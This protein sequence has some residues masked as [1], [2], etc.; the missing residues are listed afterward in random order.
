MSLL[1]C[2]S[3]SACCVICL[4]LILGAVWSVL[5]TLSFFGISPCG[6]VSFFPVFTAPSL[7]RCPC[8][9]WL[10]RTLGRPCSPVM[11]RCPPGCYYSFLISLLNDEAAFSLYAPPQRAPGTLR[12]GLVQLGLTLERVTHLRGAFVTSPEPPG[13]CLLWTR[14][15]HITGRTCPCNPRAALTSQHGV[16]PRARC[17]LPAHGSRCSPQTLP[18]VP[19]ATTAAR[20]PHCHHS[21]TVQ[22][23]KPP[24]F[25]V[26]F[27]LKVAYGLLLR[28]AYMNVK[29][30]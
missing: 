1:H 25:L 14:G 8:F 17:G 27:H 26:Q 29:S 18:F 21:L 20:S 4:W 24:L 5:A 23:V 16:L 30:E 11:L 15:L 10:S 6:A 7:T 9:P 28:Q 3:E 12:D 19:S 13:V 2:I 22:P